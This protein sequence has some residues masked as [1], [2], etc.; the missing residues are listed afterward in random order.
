MKVII[1][2]AGQVGFNIA[3][4][5]SREEN[6]VTLIDTEPRLI[7]QISDT[8]DVQGVVGYASHP[9]VLEQAGARDADLLIAVTHYDEVNMVACQVAHALFEVPRR[10][11]R[12]R[13]QSYLQRGYAELFNRQNMAIDEIISPE[14]EVAR[15]IAYRLGI[16]GAFDAIPLCDGRITLVGLRCDEDCPVVDTPLRQLTELFPDLAMSVVAIRRGERDIVPSAEDQMLVGDEVYFVADTRHLKRALAAFGHE[17]PEARRLIV[18]GGGN[19][20]T[21]LAE[22]LEQESPGVEIKLIEINRQRAERVARLLPG[23][24]VIQGDAL[25]PEILAEANVKATE[26]I[27]AVS[28]D[29]EVNILASLLAERH[30][31]KR[32]I[33]LINKPVY[34]SLIGQLGI[35]AVVSPRAITVSTILQHVRRGRI[36]SVHSVGDGLGEIIEVD[37]L[38]TSA[39][40]GRPLR[41]AKL[42]PGVLIG[43]IL[44]G[45]SMIVPRGDSVIKPED[46][47]VMFAIAKSVPLIEKMFSVKLE[48]F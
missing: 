3:R 32:S 31:C 26:T 35:D 13:S 11:A 23:S 2:G 30:G 20:G 46:R 6:D 33:A 17:E 18:V 24:V 14:I 10:I 34:G 12:V 43:A 22:I 8:L 5:L 1:C 45:D 38:P 7:E 36:R 39:L 16:P 25:D 44:R 37:A 21:F 19:I 29:D 4:Y 48:F 28:N 27:V 15:A 9:D 40:V 42:P 41:E 47:V